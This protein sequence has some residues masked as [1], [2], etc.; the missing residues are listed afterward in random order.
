MPDPAHEVRVL[1]D[2]GNIEAC[3]MERYVSDVR[4]LQEELREAIARPLVPPGRDDMD[5]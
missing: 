1:C 3:R 5:A 4:I 2:C